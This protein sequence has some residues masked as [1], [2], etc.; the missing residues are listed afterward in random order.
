MPKAR[1]NVPW[2]RSAPKSVGHHSLS[3]AQKSSA[4][5]KAQRAG[6]RYPNLI[7]NMNAAKQKK[8]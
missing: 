7:D 8:K 1:T 2:K 4:R 3:A 6:R 5:R